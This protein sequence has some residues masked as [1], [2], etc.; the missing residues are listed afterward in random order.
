MHNSQ[1][2]EYMSPF[3]IAVCLC[4]QH[5][6][7]S[8]S[9]AVVG[10]TGSPRTALSQQKRVQSF[11]TRTISTVA[12]IAGFLAIIYSGHVP[13]VVLVFSLQV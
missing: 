13:L 10:R 2:L 4:N 6:S 1:T 8:C 5:N 12:M 3:A 11:K 7:I 9:S